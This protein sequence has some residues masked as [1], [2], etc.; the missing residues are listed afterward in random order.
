MYEKI[1]ITLKKKQFDPYIA[2]RRSFKKN[3]IYITLLPF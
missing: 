1:Y 3:L 2:F